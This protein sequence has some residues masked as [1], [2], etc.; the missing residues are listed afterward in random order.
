[1]ES[2][3]QKESLFLSH[4]LAYNPRA[5]AKVFGKRQAQHEESVRCNYA[6]A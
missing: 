1:M 6:S 3:L 4:K 5:R 2:S